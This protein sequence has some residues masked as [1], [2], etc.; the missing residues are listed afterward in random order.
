M[1]GSVASFRNRKAEIR[2][3][4]T[5]HLSLRITRWL[6]WKRASKAQANHPLFVDW[7]L[8][9]D[10]L[11]FIEETRMNN[12]VAIICFKMQNLKQIFQ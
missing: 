10:L 3:F 2:W 9:N 4:Y 5:A 12:K 6:P 11:L 1:Y 7:N 8:S